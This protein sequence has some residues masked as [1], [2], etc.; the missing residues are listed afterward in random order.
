MLAFAGLK[1]IRYLTKRVL[2]RHVYRVI[3]YSDSL[4]DWLHPQMGHNVLDAARQCYLTQ[5]L[6]VFEPPLDDFAKRNFLVLVHGG[7]HLFVGIWCWFWVFFFSV[8][9]LMLLCSPK[10]QHWKQF[11][12]LVSYLRRWIIGVSIVCV[13]DTTCPCMSEKPCLW[14]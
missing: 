2:L 5:I 4:G 3:K 10:V 7:H 14:F 11:I 12:D 1:S 9:Q 13:C 6:Q 8:I